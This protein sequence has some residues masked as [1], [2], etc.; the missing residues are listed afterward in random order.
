M[1]DVIFWIVVGYCIAVIFPTPWISRAIL[2][3]W[4]LLWE[5]IKGSATTPTA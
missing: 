2:N 4:R 5:K 3:F 1:L